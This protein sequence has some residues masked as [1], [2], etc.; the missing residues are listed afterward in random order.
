MD[1]SKDF[2]KRVFNREHRNYHEKNDFTI[3]QGLKK[4]FSKIKNIENSED[5]NNTEMNCIIT[6]NTDVTQKPL[7]NCPNWNSNN[8]HNDRKRPEE[9]K[10]TC[11]SGDFSSCTFC[12]L[13]HLMDHGVHKSLFIS[14]RY[15]ETRRIVSL[16]SFTDEGQNT[17]QGC[18]KYGLDSNDESDIFDA[19]R[20]FTYNDAE[21]ETACKYC[22]LNTVVGS[23]D[24]CKKYFAGLGIQ[25]NINPEY[26]LYNT[27]VKKNCDIENPLRNFEICESS[28]LIDNL[29]LHKNPIQQ[30]DHFKNLYVSGNKKLKIDCERTRKFKKTCNENEMYWSQFI[31]D[32][33]NETAKGKITLPVVYNSNLKF[34]KSPKEVDTKFTA[35][36]HALNSMNS[37]RRP[38]K[39]E[40]TLNC[41]WALG[42]VP[43]PG[44]N[45][46]NKN[47]YLDFLD[48]MDSWKRV[49]NSNLQ[50]ALVA[51]NSGFGSSISGGWFSH[52]RFYSNAFKLKEVEER[53][54]KSC[55]LEIEVYFPGLLSN[56]L[57]NMVPGIPSEWKPDQNFFDLYRRFNV[58]LER[59]N[60]SDG[61]YKREL[62]YSKYGQISPCW[63][64]LELL[65]DLEK[66][67]NAQIIIDAQVQDGQDLTRHFSKSWM[68]GNNEYGNNGWKGPWLN[69][70]AI[71]RIEF[72]GCPLEAVK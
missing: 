50:Y 33:Q 68:F 53:N 5:Y 37:Y 8:Y 64:T 16:S 62:L 67:E 70:I 49:E 4:G 72:K 63:K 24:V 25:K 31:T 18:V 36:Y 13:P 35:L 6:E 19:T 32:T 30:K 21:A 54:R 28:Y 56:M 10:I 1:Q 52:Q 41:A 38:K 7:I 9:Q 47:G 45:C 29:E 14:K 2:W 61:S 15:L 58:F 66:N 71:R 44:I 34:A 59:R 69:Y 42:I 48:A 46:N 39:G 17:C 40:C 23:R 60:D 27:T 57:R 26:V 11:K 43:K 12:Q 22:A 65:F 20:V 55:K 51:L 3:Y